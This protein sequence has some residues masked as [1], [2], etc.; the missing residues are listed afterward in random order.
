MVS[1]SKLSTLGEAEEV[2]E[3]R[4]VPSEEEAGVLHP[5]QEADEVEVVL[6]EELDMVL[7]KVLEKGS[8]TPSIAGNAKTRACRSLCSPPTTL[9]TAPVSLLSLWRRGRTVP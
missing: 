5:S 6:L 3:E 2:E 7:L 8:G 1:T 4:G 9:S